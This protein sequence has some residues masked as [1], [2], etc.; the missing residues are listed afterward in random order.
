ME[1]EHKKLV[2]WCVLVAVII[3]GLVFRDY[4]CFTHK[5]PTKNIDINECGNKAYLEEKYK[6]YLK[7]EEI[8]YTG[9]LIDYNVSNY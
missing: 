7:P 8:N 4:Y 5:D 2:I 1:Q 6:D 9:Y 3:V